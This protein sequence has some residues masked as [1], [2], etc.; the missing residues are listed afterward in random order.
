MVSGLIGCLKK[1]LMPPRIILF[2]KIRLD[3]FWIIFKK[4]GSPLYPYLAMI[5][6]E[7]FVQLETGKILANET[8]S[9]D[10][11]TYDCFRLN[12]FNQP[13]TIS[14]NLHEGVSLLIDLK[15]DEKFFIIKHAILFFLHTLFKMKLIYITFNKCCLHA[16]VLIV[17]QNN[18]YSTRKLKWPILILFFSK[19]EFSHLFCLGDAAQHD[20]DYENQDSPLK[21]L[22]ATIIS[23][24]HHCCLQ[25][26]DSTE[27]DG[28][29]K[30]CCVC[31][32]FNRLGQRYFFNN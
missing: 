4:C 27:K 12:M 17:R 11:N 29:S 3:T 1:N 5:Y 7:I 21:M 32:M 23:T 16:I 19:K 26:I 10:C 25:K 20:R 15:E 14:L 6:V 18:S 28:E 2:I 22:K 31:S 13:T 8:I 30:E 9:M 24:I